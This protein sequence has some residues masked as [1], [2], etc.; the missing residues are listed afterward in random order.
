MLVIVKV[1]QIYGIDVNSS[2]NSS[3]EDADGYHMEN[4]GRVFENDKYEL[5][6]GTGIEKGQNIISGKV[7]GRICPMCEG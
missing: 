6:R 1:Y 2:N 3:Y 4:D 5:C 7:E